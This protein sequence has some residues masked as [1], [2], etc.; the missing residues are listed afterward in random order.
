MGKIFIRI[1]SYVTINIDI[2]RSLSTNVN[3][4]FI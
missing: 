1:P 3:M 2:T 4:Y